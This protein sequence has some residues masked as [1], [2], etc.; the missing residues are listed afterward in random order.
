MAAVVTLLDISGTDVSP[1]NELTC[2]FAPARVVFGV[3][4]LDWVASMCERCSED[5]AVF[6]E[7]SDDPISAEPLAG[8][9]LLSGRSVLNVSRRRTP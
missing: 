1:I 8:G 9:R 2:C 5:T 4:A 6:T 7:S 3:S